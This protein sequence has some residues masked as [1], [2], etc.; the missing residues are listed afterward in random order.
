MISR[1]VLGPRRVH[2]SSTGRRLAVL[3]TAAIAGYALMGASLASA[4][5]AGAI[6][7]T[8]ETCNDPAAQDANH[9]D[10]GQTVHIRGDGFD[11]N[12]TLS[13]SITGQPG[14]ASSDPGIEVAAGDVLTDGTGYFCVAAYTVLPGDDGEYTVDVES[15]SKN[16]NYRVEDEATPTDPPP[17]EP[18]PT[19]PPPTEP[20]PTPPAATPTATLPSTGS[21]KPATPTPSL[22]STSTDPSE[23]SGGTPIALLLVLLA[24][25]ATGLVV[26]DPLSKRSR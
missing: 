12:V 2:R 17:T 22:P 20:P 14:G 6:W 19:E 5:N 9:Y 8:Q 26:L 10:V 18:P 21:E 4:A 25:G 15:A 1:S 13:W 23:G 7:T 3:A 16:D 24:A 11:P